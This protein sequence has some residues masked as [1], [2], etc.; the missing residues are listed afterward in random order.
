MEKRKATIKDFLN[1][2]G[3]MTEEEK[4]AELKHFNA[5]DRANILCTE[6]I[7]ADI[8]PQSKFNQT[9]VRLSMRYGG[10]TFYPIVGW[11]P[12]ASSPFARATQ[13]PPM[14]RWLNSKIQYHLHNS[15]ENRTYTLYA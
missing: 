4:T 1:E 5:I 13:V 2:M 14:R 3:N 15:K 7:A 10:K 6:Y 8:Y 11:D 9:N 12:D